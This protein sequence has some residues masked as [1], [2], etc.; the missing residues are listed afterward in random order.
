M[1][2]WAFYGGGGGG[3]DGGASLI[4]VL[5]CLWGGRTNTTSIPNTINAIKCHYK[6]SNTFVL[7]FIVHQFNDFVIVIKEKNA[8][9]SLFFSWPP[10]QQPACHFKNRFCH[11]I[12]TQI[13]ATISFKETLRVVKKR[14]PQNCRLF[15]KEFNHKSWKQQKNLILIDL[16]IE[17]KRKHLCDKNHY[18][19]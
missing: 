11:Q 4:Y 8:A 19:F 17:R 1:N 16:K 7:L 5:H 10:N 6:K 14:H 3:D 9:H 12:M 13:N 18:L 2:A 15:I